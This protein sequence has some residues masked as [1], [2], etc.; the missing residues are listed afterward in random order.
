MPSEFEQPSKIPE[1]DSFSSHPST[2]LRNLDQDTNPQSSGSKNFSQVLDANLDEM[3]GSIRRL[4]GLAEGLS[5]E[6]DTQNDLIG[7]IT[8]KTETA[9]ITLGKQNKDM[10]RL[11]KK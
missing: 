10:G 7:N 9:D 8:E 3:Y 11:L 2:R 6:M 4:K 5:T 1:Y